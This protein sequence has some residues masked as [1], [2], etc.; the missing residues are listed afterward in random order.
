MA[1]ITLKFD[2]NNLDVI[3]TELNLT[4]NF[5]V[6]MSSFEKGDGRTDRQSD[7][8]CYTDGSRMDERAGAG[9][10]IMNQGQTT[11]GNR[12]LGLQATVFQA[13]ISA[14]IDATRELLLK[15]ARGK[16]DFIVDSQAAIQALQGRTRRTR[17]K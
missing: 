9:W 16:V 2:A 8:A 6:N 11:S 14:I 13:E 17:W 5:K 10:V 12:H 1:A 15:S 4:K 7:H 3:P